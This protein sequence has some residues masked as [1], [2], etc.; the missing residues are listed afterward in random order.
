MRYQVRWLF[1]T[2]LAL[3]TAKK[4][5]QS[6][7]CASTVCVDYLNGCD[8]R[9]GGCYAACS[10]YAIPTYSDPGCPLPTSAARYAATSTSTCESTICVDYINSCGIR[11]GGCYEAC[12]GYTKPTY[13]APAC[14]TIT[15]TVTPT[16]TLTTL[17]YAGHALQAVKTA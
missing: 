2:T 3:S 6:T 9:W 1:A 16:A 13:T 4:T 14:P 15:T 17:A 12:P 8:Q 5:K 7:A 11:Y 10:G